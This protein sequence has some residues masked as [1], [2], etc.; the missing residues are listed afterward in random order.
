MS[1]RLGVH[2]GMIGLKTPVIAA[3]GEH[4]I[5][6][7]GL[8]AAIRSGAGAVVMKSTNESEAAKRQLRQAEYVALGPD[9]SP[10]P[11][12][13]P[14]PGDTVL[15]RS[16]LHPLPF[17]DWLDQMMRMDR[18]A[19]GE[20]CLLVPSLVLANLETAAANARS[21]E[22]AGGRLLELNIG[23]PYASQ[24]ACGAVAT[25]LDP[26]RV[27]QIVATLRTA[28][29]IP[30]WVKLSGQS[31]RV[32]ELAGA[33]V[34]A[35]ADS[36]VI[37]GR[38]LG[39]VPDLETM[40]PILGTSG[41][42]G[43]SWNLPMTCHWVAETRAALGAGQPLIGING[44]ASGADVARMMLAGATAAGLSSAVMRG[45]FGVLADAIAAL[46]AYCAAR[47]TTAADLIGRAADCRQRFADLP[48]L[49]DVWRNHIPRGVAAAS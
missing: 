35:G 40:R 17:S 46:D 4:M 20:N 30:I 31:E 15:T 13:V 19:R 11:W 36:V 29:S 34:A 28:I 26:A 5:E 25:E 12:D 38:A 22:A 16:G 41:G 49:D 1:G 14:G 7:A 21:V 44:A 32:T 43:G 33:A 6:D 10:V 47:D 37:A 27:G 9:W 48:I 8:I 42:V 23:T 24:A 39:L 45:G 3:P 2:I 18:I